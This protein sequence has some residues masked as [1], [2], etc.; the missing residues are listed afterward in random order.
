MSEPQYYI[1][2]VNLE[3]KWPS[4]LDFPLTRIG[5]HPTSVIN[6]PE[7]GLRRNMGIFRRQKEGFFLP[8]L[9]HLTPRD[10]L[11]RGSFDRRIKQLGK[12][13]ILN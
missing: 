11:D 6:S 2:R 13:L 12:N 1:I 5:T 9:I 3:G 4:R 8:L 7:G 10:N